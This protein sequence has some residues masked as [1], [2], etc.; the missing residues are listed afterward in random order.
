MRCR[1][2]LNLDMFGQPIKLN[3]IGESTEYRSTCGA[4]FSLVINMT[5]LLYF[6][7]QLRVLVGYRASSFVSHTI[8]NGL[9][10]ELVLGV[11]DEFFFAVSIF[12][13]SDNSMTY[14]DDMRE[15]I[16]IKA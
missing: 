15:F 1:P 9:D 16:E 10:P 7:Q 14:F 8:Q 4:L 3:Y 5:T 12:D 11:E 13:E 2:L 6:V